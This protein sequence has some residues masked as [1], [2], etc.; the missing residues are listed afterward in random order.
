MERKSLILMILMI[1][2]CIAAGVLGA[3]S[4][5]RNIIEVYY[6]AVTVTE[7]IVF[8]DAA[9]ADDVISDGDDTVWKNGGTVTIPAGMTGTIRDM[10]NSRGDE[11]GN[12]RIRVDF[13]LDDGTIIMAVIPTDPDADTSFSGYVI[14]AGKIESGQEIISEYKQTRETYRTRVRN[15]WILGILI[16]IGSAIM[17]T[18][19]FIVFNRSLL[20]HNKS[21]AIILRLLIAVVIVVAIVLLFEYGSLK[22]I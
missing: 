18:V 6:K 10:V 8:D 5:E 21:T 11:V 22:Y 3:Y 1:A 20:K 15:T 17:L 14:D 9:V 19:F 4:H 12:D 16:G 13:K 7:D 2:A